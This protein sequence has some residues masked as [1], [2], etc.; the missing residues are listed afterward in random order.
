MV[1]LALQRKN[2]VLSLVK[3]EKQRFR[4][5]T[6][7]KYHIFLIFRKWQKSHI[8]SKTKIKQNI[9]SKIFDSFHNKS[10]EQDNGEK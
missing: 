10:M 9:I 7:C 5:S 3:H 1:V 8:F 4:K 6:Q 2:L